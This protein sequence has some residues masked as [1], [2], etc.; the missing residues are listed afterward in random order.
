MEANRRL[1]GCLG[2]DGRTGGKENKGGGTDKKE[3][4]MESEEEWMDGR[5]DGRRA[6]GW[7][8]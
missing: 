3:R 6:G 4:C 1:T 8:D 7:L 2:R 5:V